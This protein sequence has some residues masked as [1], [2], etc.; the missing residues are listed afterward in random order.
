MKLAMV[1]RFYGM[2]FI[3]GLAM[4]LLAGSGLYSYEPIPDSSPFTTPVPYTAIY[5]AIMCIGG[6]LA[7]RAWVKGSRLTA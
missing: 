5:I 1:L 3:G 7:L 6:F 2:P 4:L